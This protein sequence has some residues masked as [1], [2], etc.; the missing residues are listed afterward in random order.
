MMNLSNMDPQLL[1]MLAA[2]MS[3]GVDRGPS[4]MPTPGP[5]PDPS[6]YSAQMMSPEDLPYL[7]RLF[8][9][10]EMPFDVGGGIKSPGG[11]SGL[12]KYFRGTRSLPRSHPNYGKRIKTGDDFWDSKLFVTDSIEGAKLYGDSV[13]EVV[14]KKGSRILREGTKGFP[15][16]E[17]GENMLEWASRVAK[18]AMAD[19]YDA[20]HFNRQTDIGTIVLN[21]DAV[22]RGVVG[23]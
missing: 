12:L 17:K 15:R 21:E 6:S 4:R 8:R 7:D 9:G 23:P 1:R 16:W 11:V 20:V 13:E 5:A 2:S 10:D 14:F 3:T 19:G 18:K 22:T